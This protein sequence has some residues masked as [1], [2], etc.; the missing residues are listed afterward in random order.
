MS[1]AGNVTDSPEIGPPPI[2]H[3]EDPD[4]YGSRESSKVKDQD[5]PAVN[6]A[7]N[8]ETRKKRR[9]SMSTQQRETLRAANLV[10]E[11]TA[12]ESSTNREISAS[13]SSSSDQL[14][15][16]AGA[17]RK[18]SVR[19]R[20]DGEHSV[21]ANTSQ[22]EGF[23][24]SRRHGGDSDKSILTS[25][26]QATNVRRGSTDNDDMR[27]RPAQNV[28]DSE[29]SVR[30]GVVRG[31]PN[32]NTKKETLASSGRTAL[33]PSK[34]CALFPAALKLTCA[35]CRIYEYRSSIAS[36]NAQ[37]CPYGKGQHRSSQGH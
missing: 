6:V 37:G 20:E 3:F 7:V 5:G 21:A 25:D 9:E 30:V 1:D 27:I 29:N 17:K 10:D 26:N 35:S 18:L 19:D 36:E 34:I 8:S 4:R 32:S 13:R 11:V 14:A 15:F 2:A 33:A 24:F 16:K 31:R 28:L 23:R 22:E 12:D